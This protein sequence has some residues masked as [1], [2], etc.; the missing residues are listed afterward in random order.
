MENNTIKFLIFVDCLI[1]K[2]LDSGNLNLKTK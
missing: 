2:S 1:E